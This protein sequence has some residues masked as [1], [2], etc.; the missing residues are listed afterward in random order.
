MASPRVKQGLMAAGGAGGVA[1]FMLRALGIKVTNNIQQP[2]MV[3]DTDGTM[4]CVWNL[5]QHGSSSYYEPMI[6][7]ISPDG[8][9]NWCKKYGWTD[10]FYTVGAPSINSTYLAIPM[11][12]SNA[13]AFAV[14]KSNG[15]LALAEKGTAGSYS[16]SA[17]LAAKD[18]G[19][20]HHMFEYQQR[21]YTFTYD[22]SN[23]FSRTGV[24]QTNS[25]F[26]GGYK[27]PWGYMSAWEDNGDYYTLFTYPQ[28]GSYPYQVF[29][30]WDSNGLGTGQSG[31]FYMMGTSTGGHIRGPMYQIEP[32]GDWMLGAD[33]SVFYTIANNWSS[34]RKY[35]L[36]GNARALHSNGIDNKV[37]VG[38][39]NGKI[40]YVNL[41]SLSSPSI[42]HARTIN[43]GY[44]QNKGETYSFGG[45]VYDG[46]LYIT[47]QE[48][49]FDSGNPTDQYQK[50]IYLFAY[51]LDAPFTGT[52]TASP[53]NVNFANRSTSIS[54]ADYGSIT[55]DT[56]T[57][58]STINS[59]N[60]SSIASAITVTSL[61]PFSKFEF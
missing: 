14:N 34:P 17:I 52:I 59:L 36:N 16:V 3:A 9:V 26:G 40:E 13:C 46:K 22:T 61:T 25:S 56:W 54:V 48:E 2:Q 7:S 30:K 12:A 1:D 5:Y 20:I 37:F 24:Q 19:D 31:T 45:A 60:H 6:A 23:S 57:A 8:T 47:S 58:G 29:V 33:S 21:L 39:N 18:T 50:N 44:Q 32:S 10:H 49:Y 4:Y 11:A 55:S 27:Y 15:N 38:N 41:S 53:Q 28:Y 51:D 43:T 35:T 42:D